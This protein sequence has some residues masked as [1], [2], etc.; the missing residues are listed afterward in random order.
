[1]NPLA[2]CILSSR[3]PVSDEVAAF[4]LGEFFQAVLE[5]DGPSELRRIYAAFY[6]QSHGELPAID[7]SDNTGDGSLKVKPGAMAATNGK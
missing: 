6:L 7:W 5:M 3:D 4:A 2:S 1:M